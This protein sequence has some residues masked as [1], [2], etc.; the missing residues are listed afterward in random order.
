[1]LQ[2]R[3]GQLDGILGGNLG[4]S[5]VFILKVK[6]TVATLLT[7]HVTQVRQRHMDLRKAGAILKIRTYL[8]DLGVVTRMRKF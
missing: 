5:H 1:M 3:G 6:C 4:E 7:A 8:N 2:T